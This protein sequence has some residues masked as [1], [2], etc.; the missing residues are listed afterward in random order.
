MQRFA[1]VLA[2]C[3]VA[4]APARAEFSYDFVDVFYGQIDFDD[5]NV[6][7]DNFGARLSL[8][9]NDEFHLFGGGGFA[10]LDFNADA[11]TWQAGVGYN[12]ELSPVIDLVAQLSYRR[13]D[14]DTPFGDAED[15]G[16]GL[17]V[18][19][20][21]AMTDLVEFNGSIDYSDLDDTGDNIS[22]GGA[23]LFN[24]TERFSVGL[25]GDF[26]DDVSEYSVVGR[27]YF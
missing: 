22:L 9:I 8:S 3:F 26:D 25:F 4:A 19:F 20:R 6:D 13:V 7:G 2:L 12:T 16:F 17:G 11:T 23:V 15:N 27:I 18:I 24:L 14:L 21:V 5:V 10:D 1:L